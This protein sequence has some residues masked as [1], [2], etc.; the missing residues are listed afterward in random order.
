MGPDDRLDQ[1]SMPMGLDWPIL[2]SGGS[3]GPKFGP[4]LGQIWSKLIFQAINA[5]FAPGVAFSLHY[6]YSSQICNFFTFR[7][8]FGPNIGPDLAQIGSKTGPNLVY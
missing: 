7:G 1:L 2:T 5:K 8:R 3:F 4:D 6:R